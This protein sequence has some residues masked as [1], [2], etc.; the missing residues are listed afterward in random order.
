MITTYRLSNEELTKMT[1]LKAIYEKN[2]Y[3]FKPDRFPEIYYDDFHKVLEEF[4][5]NLF[6]HNEDSDG[7]PDYL[8]VYIPKYEWLY[9]YR[10]SSEGIIILFKDRIEKFSSNSLIDE[11]HIRFVV[12]MHELGHW[13]SHFAQQSSPPNFWK[14]GYDFSNRFTKE[15]FA[16]LTAYWAS[17]DDP[18]NLKTLF[19]LSPK[20][21]TGE[22]NPLAIYGNY[23]R[24][25]KF[26]K[27]EIL[28]KLLQVRLYWFLDDRV[29][30][31]FLNSNSV[32]IIEW[33]VNEN[34]TNF[35]EILHENLHPQS[36]EFFN[37]EKDFND[38]VQIILERVYGLDIKTK[39][40]L[41]D[42]GL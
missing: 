8:G 17:E 36:N 41:E 9:G 19:E 13:L 6:E 18:N 20:T 12:L 4:S 25:V 34:K 27:V 37:G 1:W 38:K 42:F 24:L 40:T 26:S 31:D 3:K 14:F 11:K 21:T 35:N 15:A 10:E 23:I 28:R 29:F 30:I 22:I 32:F 5:F 16:Q 7:N 39:D 2:N 33:L